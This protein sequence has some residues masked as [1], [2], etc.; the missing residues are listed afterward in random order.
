[1]QVHKKLMQARVA[2][3]AMDIKKSGF[4]G[5]SEYRYFE[6]G[7]FLVPALRLFNDLGLCGVVSFTPDTA[8]L[9]IT[10]SEDGSAIVITS[11]M[12]SAKLKACH[13]VQNIGA[14]ETFQRR[15]LWVT[16]LEITEHDALDATTAAVDEGEGEAGKARE[17]ADLR[18][19]LAGLR[20]TT[21]DEAARDYWRG[22]NGQFN[23]QDDAYEAFKQ[24]VIDHRTAIK[25]RAEAAQPQR[26]HAPKVAA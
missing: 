8:T 5:F 9:T 17:P 4:N 12:G 24:A 23:G 3:H 6:L 22:H 18:P 14:V 13:E 26:A 21:T 2:L 25:A 1:M 10:D 20:A 7:D 11:P 19:L 15:Y 16:A